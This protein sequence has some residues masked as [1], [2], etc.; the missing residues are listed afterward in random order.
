M[1]HVERER[2]RERERAKHAALISAVL[3]T[4]WML[5]ALLGGSANLIL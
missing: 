2:E 5:F 3:S 1:K 4:G